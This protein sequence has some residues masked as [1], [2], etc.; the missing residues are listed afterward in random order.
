M[1]RT[2]SP[3]GQAAKAAQWLKKNEQT[4]QGKQFAKVKKTYKKTT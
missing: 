3:H 4:E 1:K 2:V